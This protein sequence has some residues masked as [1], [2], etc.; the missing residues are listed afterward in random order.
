[1]T[2][3]PVGRPTARGADRLLHRRPR[4]TED[5]AHHHAAAFLR[6]EPRFG[7]PLAPGPATNQC[8]FAL[9]SAHGSLPSAIRCTTRAIPPPIRCQGSTSAHPV[10]PVLLW[11]NAARDSSAW[12][13]SCRCRRDSGGLQA[14]GIACLERTVSP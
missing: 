3:R 4:C 9:Q 7:R 1:H 6:E 13:T 2:H 5:V 8:N 11:P 10:N 12:W 14:L